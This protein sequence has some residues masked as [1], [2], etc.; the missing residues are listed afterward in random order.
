MDRAVD[1]QLTGL[2][3]YSGLKALMFYLISVFQAQ[4][5]SSAQLVVPDS[6]GQ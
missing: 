1:C 4:E 3:V 2:N 6:S 5:M